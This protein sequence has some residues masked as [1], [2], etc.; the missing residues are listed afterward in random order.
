[1]TSSPD[2]ESTQ[3]SLDQL[4]NQLENSPTTVEFNQVIEV[5]NAHYHYTPTRFTNGKG[6]S[7]VSNEAGTNEGSCKIFA[8]AQDQQLG[9]EQTLNCFGDYY[10]TDVLKNPDG[11]D[12]GNI[13]GFIQFGWDGIKFDEPALQVK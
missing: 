9:E 3:S 10:R 11:N 8:F 2:T 5:I 6:D 1:M 7:Q 4:L 13:R 12:H